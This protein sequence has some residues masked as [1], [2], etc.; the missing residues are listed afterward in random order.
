MILT[1]QQ[2]A[3]CMPGLR[4]PR[5]SQYL[6]LLVAAIT[7]GRIDTRL[8]VAAFLAQLGHESVDLKHFEE[9]ASGQAYEGRRDLG[10]I[11]PGDGPRFKGR[12]PIQ[13]TGRV[14]YRAAGCALGVDLEGSPELAALPEYGFRIAVWFWT[15]RRLNEKADAQ[16]FDAITSSINGGLNGKADRDARYARCLAALPEAALAQDDIIVTPF[17]LSGIVDLTPHHGDRDT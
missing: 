11:Y 16:Q 13:L 15:S 14:N 3:Q 1:S 6:P 4:E 8:R 7:E 10:N 17:D 12:G 9:L 5:L 2:L